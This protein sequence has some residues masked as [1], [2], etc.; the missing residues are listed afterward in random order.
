MDDKLKFALVVCF[1]LIAVILVVSYTNYQTT[2]ELTNLSNLTLDNVSTQ[3]NTTDLF[4]FVESLP[5]V[6]A[7]VSETLN[8]SNSTN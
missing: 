7:N 1:F 4:E 3:L 8:I 2:Q 6:T 5:N